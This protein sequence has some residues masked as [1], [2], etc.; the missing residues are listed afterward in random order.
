MGLVM[1]SS[2][3]IILG[4]GIVEGRFLRRETQI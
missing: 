3:S 2:V 4:N 1:G